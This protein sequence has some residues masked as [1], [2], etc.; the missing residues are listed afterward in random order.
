[1]GTKNDPLA[2]DFVM[3][4]QR[5]R[6][7]RNSLVSQLQARA[8]PDSLAALSQLVAEN[9]GDW[10]LKGALA[11]AEDRDHNRLFTIQGVVGV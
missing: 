4:E 1:M 11:E 3:D 9:S 8:T 6:E 2:S 5:V 10:S 7:W